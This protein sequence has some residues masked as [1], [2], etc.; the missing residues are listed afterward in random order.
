MPDLVSV[1][2]NLHS[3]SSA[4]SGSRGVTTRL[5]SG[6]NFAASS[7]MAGLATDTATM[8]VGTVT[9]EAARGG[10]SPT[11]TELLS[12]GSE[13]G[14]FTFGGRCKLRRRFA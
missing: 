1:P 11:E 9:T 4:R 6:V 7:T 8:E 12:V 14:M 3:S 2:H 10:S 13:H 5:G